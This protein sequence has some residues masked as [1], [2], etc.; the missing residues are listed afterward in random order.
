MKE[1]T[2]KVTKRKAIPY[3]INLKCECGG[4][5]IKDEP[6]VFDS[7]TMTIK[8]TCDKCGKSINSKNIYPNSLNISDEREEDFGTDTVLEDFVNIIGV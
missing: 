3:I 8:H 5:Y 7:Q 4:K 1:V 2:L 6:L